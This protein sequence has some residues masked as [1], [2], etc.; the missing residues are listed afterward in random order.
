MTKEEI[1]NQQRKRRPIQ[2]GEN[3]VIKIHWSIIALKK[4][5]LYK[6]TQMVKLKSS[7]RLKFYGRH[8]DLMNHFL[9][10]S[11]IGDPKCFICIDVVYYSS[12]NDA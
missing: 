12:T 4:T 6:G 1:G 8:H 10:M 2:S 3:T 9:K 11:V 7:L 5:K